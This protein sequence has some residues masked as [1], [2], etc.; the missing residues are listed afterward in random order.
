MPSASN[1][2]TNTPH[3]PV[4]LHACVY[5][6]SVWESLSQH[7]LQLT[8]AQQAGSPD[9][10]GSVIVVNGQQQSVV[11]AAVVAATVGWWQ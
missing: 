8:P 4:K 11:P 2:H 1:I 7:L 10:R 9:G 5:A 3:T 6:D